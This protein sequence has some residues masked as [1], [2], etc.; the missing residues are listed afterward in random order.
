MPEPL[1]NNLHKSN[2]TLSAF[3]FQSLFIST[4]IAMFT[5]FGFE[6]ET[7]SGEINPALF[8]PFEN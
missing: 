2:K 1:T 5:D 8:D 7:F 6:I 4:N 3:S